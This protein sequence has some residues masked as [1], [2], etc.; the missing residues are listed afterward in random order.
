MLVVKRPRRNA[1]H[2][3]Q[4]RASE[5]DPE[6]VVNVLRDVSDDEGEELYEKSDLYLAQPDNPHIARIK[7]CGDILRRWTVAMLTGA[8][9]CV[10]P[11]SPGAWSVSEAR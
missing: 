1:D 5:S 8:L 9:P 11:Q 4:R 3:R 10:V 7:R 6:S 2:K